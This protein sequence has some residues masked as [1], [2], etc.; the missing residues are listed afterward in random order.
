MYSS[1][2]VSFR[3][4]SMSVKQLIDRI[5]YERIIFRDN[6]FRKYTNRDAPS[7]YSSFI[8][9]VMMDLPLLPLVF[10]GSH[11]PWYIMDGEKRL[12]AIWNFANNKFALKNIFYSRLPENVYF[13]EMSPFLK[14]HFL[15]SEVPCYIINPGT[16]QDIIDD[17]QDRIHTI[18]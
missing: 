5:D 3:T 8:E 6:V 12:Q 11:N 10:D 17:I 4:Q 9:S 16:P 13:N 7:C 1:D 2:Y 15:K 14:H 18:L